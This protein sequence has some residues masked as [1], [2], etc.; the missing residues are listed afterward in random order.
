VAGEQAVTQ[1]PK[2]FVDRL[3]QKAKA[4]ITEDMR[5]EKRLE[6]AAELLQADLQD[7]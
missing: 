5:N 4:R 2:I 3:E 6:A 7:D 1:A